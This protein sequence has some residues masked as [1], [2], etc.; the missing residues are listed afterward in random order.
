MDKD[1]GD[2]GQ[3]KGTSWSACVTCKCLTVV[4]MWK[5]A[6]VGRFSDFVF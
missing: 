3:Q 1:I 6:S 4:A 5:Q 2:P